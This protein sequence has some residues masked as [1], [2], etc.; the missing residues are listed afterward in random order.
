MN[1]EQLLGRLLM[2]G[3]INIDELNI[4]SSNSNSNSNAA[5]IKIVKQSAVGEMEEK[6]VEDQSQRLQNWIKIFDGNN[7]LNKIN[8]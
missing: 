5:N 6:F 3:H 7:A 4:L 2:N 1:K 8:I